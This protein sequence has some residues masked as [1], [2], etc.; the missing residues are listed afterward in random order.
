MQAPE[1]F[2]IEPAFA[3]DRTGTFHRG[4]QSKLSRPVTVKILRAELRDDPAA[5]DLFLEERGI[6]AGLEHPNLLLTLAVGE[7][8][9]LPFF[10]TEP[11]ADATLA[12][13]LSGEE[14][15]AEP[16]AVAIAIGIARALVYLEEKG[17]IYKNVRPPNVLLPRPV[18]PKLLTFRHVRSVAEAPRFRAA[19]VQTGAYCAPEL[20]RKDLG[21]VTIKANVYALGGILYELLAGI[22]PVDGASAEARAANAAGRL[23][24]L[25]DVRPFLRDRAYATVGR[26]L[27]HDPAV[28]PGPAE[29]L[30]ML[31]EYATDP[32]VA[33]PLRTR[34]RKRRR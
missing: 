6:V 29:A 4:V 8:D 23:R 9:G 10:V 24:P 11:V 21:D 25:K 20:V 19:Q 16:V 33:H 17:L 14:L 1:G 7:V 3:K 18:V 13:A 22:P 27:S 30:R 15:P 5:R 12:Q 26:L 31:E 2:S 32:L 34:R 28:R